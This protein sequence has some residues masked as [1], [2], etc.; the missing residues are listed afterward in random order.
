M[1][2]VAEDHWVKKGSVKLYVYRKHDI[3]GPANKP[4]LFLVH[5]STFSSRGTYDVMV[6]GKGDHSAMEHFAGLGYDVW[7]MDHEGYGYSDRTDSNSGIM[8]GVEDLKAAM[9]LVLEKS[10]QKSVRLFG[11][12]SGAIKAGAYANAEPDK[13]E[14]LMLHALTYT[15]THAPEMERRRRMADQFRAN[16]RRPF[17]QAQIDNVFNRDKSGVADPAIVKAVGDFELKFGD[18]IPSGTYLDMAVNMPMVDPTKLTCSVSMIRPDHDANATDEELYEFFVNLA[19]RDKQFIMMRG[20]PHG[21]GMVNHQRHRLWH[22][23]HAF[24]SSPAAPP[25]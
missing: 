7:T 22:A 14:R 5:G 15:G 2:I 1:K 17:G 11:E 4:V 21:G 6:G 12:S 10:G 13:V 20:L 16:P 24:M 8:V 9:P 25:E 3:D 23:M 18:S 19:T